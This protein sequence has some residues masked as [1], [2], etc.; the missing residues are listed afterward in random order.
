ML[1]K[2]FV[3]ELVQPVVAHR[4]LDGETERLVCV[5]AKAIDRLVSSWEVM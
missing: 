3:A 2:E 5:R 1:E 4:V